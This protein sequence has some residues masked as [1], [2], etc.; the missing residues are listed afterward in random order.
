MVDKEEKIALQTHATLINS[1]VAEIDFGYH[2][3][4]DSYIIYPGGPN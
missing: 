4:N 2:H 1:K 3:V